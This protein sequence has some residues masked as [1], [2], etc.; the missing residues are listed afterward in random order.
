MSTAMKSMLL[1]AAVRGLRSAAGDLDRVGAL[2]LA[3]K[4]RSLASEIEYFA[5]NPRKAMMVGE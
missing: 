5:S 1:H 2:A 3:I 4:T